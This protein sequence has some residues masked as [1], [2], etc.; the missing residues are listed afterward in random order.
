MYLSEIRLWNF[1]KF[2]GDNN[3]D[4]ARPHLIVPFKNKL[5]ISTDAIIARLLKFIK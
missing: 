5:N 3:I 4:L 2:G 1:R